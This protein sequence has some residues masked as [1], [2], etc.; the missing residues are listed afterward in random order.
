MANPTQQNARDHLYSR[1]FRPPM[2][3]S[4]D[5]PFPEHL[6]FAAQAQTGHDIAHL[7][8]ARAVL[9]K[10]QPVKTVRVL[11]MDVKEP[12]DAAAADIAPV[13]LLNKSVRRQ[14]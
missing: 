13:L 1:L 5:R 4:I 9:G 10:W 2:F 8:A 12:V 3:P 6:Q 11:Q 7:A 14:A